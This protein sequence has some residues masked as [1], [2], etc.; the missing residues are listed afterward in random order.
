MCNV[1]R[2]QHQ[3]LLM[4]NELTDVRRPEVNFRTREKKNGLVQYLSLKFIHFNSI[5]FE[6]ARTANTNDSPLFFRTHIVLR[7]ASHSVSFIH[8]GHS[9][10]EVLVFVAR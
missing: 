9:E 2:R 7:A 4:M 5:L 1:A 10:C 8:Y 6:H 3:R